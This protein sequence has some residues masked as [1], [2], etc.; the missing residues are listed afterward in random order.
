MSR[1][2]PDGSDGSTCGFIGSFLIASK[3]SL[4]K[5]IALCIIYTI[6]RFTLVSIR[7]FP[8]PKY[9]NLIHPYL[10]VAAGLTSLEERAVDFAL[11]GGG[12]EKGG[13]RPS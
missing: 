7:K 9:P 13:S 8:N 12:L 11:D 4:K 3:N 5:Y 1:E 10:K 6:K 2:Q